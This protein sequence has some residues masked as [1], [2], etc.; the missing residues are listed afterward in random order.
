MASGRP[1]SGWSTGLW[2]WGY[3]GDVERK[4]ISGL[5]EPLWEMERA[6]GSRDSQGFS[7]EGGYIWTWS[8]RERMWLEIRVRGHWSSDPSEESR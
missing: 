5:G 7:P 1:P 2:Q 8:S 4:Q 3:K 6:Y